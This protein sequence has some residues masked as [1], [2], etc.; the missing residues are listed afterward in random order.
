VIVPEDPIQKIGKYEIVEEVGR[1]AMGI[2]YKA[3]DPFIGRLVALKTVTP[4]LLSDPDL[5]KRFYREAQSAGKLQHANIVVIH[6]LGESNGLPYIA[7][8]LVEG[9]SLQKI[10]GRRTAMPLAQKLRLMVQLCHGL[11]YAHQHGVV[12][13]DVKPANILVKPDGTIKVVDFGIVHLTETGMTSSGM[14]L[15]TVSY[16]SP[17]QL[18]GEHVDARSDIFSVGIV[19]Y[20]LLSYQK[21]FD[22]PNIPAVML[23]IA[24]EDPVPLT[25]LVPAIP[26]ALEQAV[27]KCLRKDREE[28]FQNLD[29]LALELEPLARELQREVLDGMIEQ[30][31]GFLAQGEFARAEEVLRSALAL[32]SSHDAAKALMAKAQTELRRLKIAARVKLYMDEGRH[33]LDQG[34]YVEASQAFEEVLR[35]DSQHGQAR[36]LLQA[37]R[38]AVAKA[39]EGRRRLLEAKRALSEGDFTLAE[40]ELRKAL[41]VDAEQTEAVSLLEKI[42][43]ERAAREKRLRFRE[44]VSSARDML[45]Q[46]R[47]EEALGQLQ[48]LH[49]EFPQ[50]T[51]VEPLLAAAQQKIEQRQQLRNAFSEVKALLEQQK[52]EEA[53][54]LAETVRFQFP[55]DTESTRLCEFAKTEQSLAERRQRLEFEV[56]ALQEQIKAQEYDAALERGERLQREFPGSVELARLVMLARSER[57]AVQLASATHIGTPSASTGTR[58]DEIGRSAPGVLKP[59]AKSSVTGPGS[60]PVEVRKQSP[61]SI[62]QGVAQ[63][64]R[65]S[66]PALRE[67]S[68]SPRRSQV[69]LLAAGV[70]VAVLAGVSYVLFHKPV[71]QPARQQ[72]PAP[73]ISTLQSPIPTTS[74]HLAA[75]VI[76]G[77]VR[78]AA[79][80]AVAGVRVTASGQSGEVSNST[81]GTDGSFRMEKLEPG[82]YVIRAE[83]PTGYSAPAEFTVEVSESGERRIELP[84]TGSA[85]LPAEETAPNTQQA[86][87]PE[88]EAGAP[89]R[90]RVGGQ[91]QQAKWIFHPSPEYPPLAKDAHVQGT[92]RLEAIIGKD[93]T[94]Q[95]LKAI[96]GHPLLIKAALD[97][98]ARWRYQPTRLRGEPVEVVTEI[99]VKFTLSSPEASP[100]Q[101]AT[102]ATGTGQLVVSANVSGAKIIIDGNDSGEVTPHIF[103]ALPAR[104]HTVAVTKEGYETAS[105]T[106]VVEAGGSVTANLQLVPPVMEPGYLEF[107]TDPAGVEVFIDDKSYGPS[108]VKT[109]LGPGTHT[110]RVTLGSEVKRG[111]FEVKSGGFYQKK[112]NF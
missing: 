84:L 52:F 96:S 8:E 23:K 72:A 18:R 30:G 3:R 101:A 76:T 28:R 21:P 42:R 89:K 19:M 26:S 104:T 67:Q 108:P 79:G 22:G 106:F 100:K 10:I 9:E 71:P 33:L 75:G 95:D 17:E 40:S 99:D 2:V 59:E 49:N 46:E 41:A 55:Q 37:A 61:E 102:A 32:D 66:E 63:A 16:M 73:G 83:P 12:H 109:P 14:V 50:E 88:A 60:P 56:T 27:G 36:G 47:Y 53:I 38:E 5:L 20:E 29:D 74:P 112:V 54:N 13:R 98:V 85:A 11:G 111:S 78:D 6:D 69:I 65:V 77:R 45:R 93:G 35:L 86:T 92:V 48:M 51:E 15:G 25:T 68:E 31:R 57:Q 44:G 110:Y 64:P 80:T 4:G 70:L 94:I 97:A 87:L 81:S 91:S 24:S 1:G 82:S 107:I 39:A 103:S 105:S 58:L 90:I 43:E 34:K 62:A 7:M